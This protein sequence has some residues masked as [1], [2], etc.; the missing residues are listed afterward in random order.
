MTHVFQAFSI[1]ANASEALDKLFTDS[2]KKQMPPNGL[3]VFGNNHIE[4]MVSSEPH[5][6]V[7]FA[8]KL[9]D[10]PVYNI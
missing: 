3:K 1:T 6:C 2:L 7:L 10:F 9:D 8:F 5:F 4:E